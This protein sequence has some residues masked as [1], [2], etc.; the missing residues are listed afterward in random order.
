MNKVRKNLKYPSII[1]GHDMLVYFSLLY[2]LSEQFLKLPY[3]HFIKKYNKDESN[4][5]AQIYE[6]VLILIIC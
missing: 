2:F 6:V 5:T 3:T 1:H 4:I